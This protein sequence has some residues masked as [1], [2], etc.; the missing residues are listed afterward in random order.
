MLPRAR[1]LEVRQLEIDW[2]EGRYGPRGCF[3]MA[4]VFHRLNRQRERR[5]ELGLRYN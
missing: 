3:T 2:V 4:Q 5:M 1:A